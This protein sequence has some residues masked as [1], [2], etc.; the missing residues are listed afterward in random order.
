VRCVDIKGGRVIVRRV[1]APPDLGTM[2]TAIFDERNPGEPG[3]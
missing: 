2:D 3:A 1:A